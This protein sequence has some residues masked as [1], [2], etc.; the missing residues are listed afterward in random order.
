MFSPPISFYKLYIKD[1]F[2]NVIT[3][4]TMCHLGW[5]QRSLTLEAKQKMKEQYLHGYS[6]I[7]LPTLVSSMS[8]VPSFT[9]LPTHAYVPT[10][11]TWCT[12]LLT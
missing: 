7:H 1:V 8:Y 6:L 2:S 11:I 12:Y 10:Y 5:T 4:K 9:Y 3:L